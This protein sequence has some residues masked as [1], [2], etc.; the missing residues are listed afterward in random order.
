LG[1][2]V[3]IWHE[4][5]A[6]INVDREPLAALT[7]EGHIHGCLRLEIAG[8]LVPCLGYWG[9]DDVC[10]D[11]WVVEL[12]RAAEAM[13]IPGSRYVFDEGEQGQPAFVFEREGDQAF[14]T[15]A[16]S[17]LSDG[18]AR[19]DWQRVEF[20]PD[21]FVTAYENF[22]ESF[23]AEVRAGA[24]AVAEAWLQRFAR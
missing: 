16:A 6:S 19:P 23:F 13:R 24:P 10:F 2:T 7:T 12:F 11:A 21:E 1:R 20:S 5:L 15:I 14:F 17:S 9:P 22:R 8:R 4:N 18:V 3:R